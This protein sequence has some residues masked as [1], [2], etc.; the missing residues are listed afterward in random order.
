MMTMRRAVV[1]LFLLFAAV[2][3]SAAPALTED[4]RIAGL[5][6]IWSEAKFGFVYFD[7]VPELDWD[8][9]YLDYLPRVRAAASTLDYYKL[10]SRFV[11]Q[12]KDGHTDVTPPLQ[13][14]QQL[15][16]EPALR[17]GE[18]EERVVVT[19]IFD[20]AL[21]IARGTELIAVDGVPVRQYAAERVTPYVSASTPQDLAQ[22][23]WRR[24][25]WGAEGSDVELTL[26]DA[27]GATV[28][29][30]V[31]RLTSEEEARILPARVPFELRMLPGRIAY[32]ALNEFDDAKAAD[33]F[34]AKFDEIAKAGALILDIRRNG[35][36]SS[37]VG[38]R[39]LA[40]LTA[41]PFRTSMWK[42]R[43]YSATARAW[44]E[45]ERIAVHEAEE[46]RPNGTRLFTNPVVV[47]TSARTFSAA[48]DFAVAFDAMKRGAIIGEPTGGST[49][50]PLS[51]PLPGGG[52]ARICTKHDVYPD[53]REFVGVGVQ[54]QLV[55][56]PTL[57]DVRAGRDTVL[58]AAIAFLTKR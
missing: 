1:V 12:L 2:A 54:P 3:A 41:K 15:N 44:G 25:L 22:R 32:I 11:A 53:G 43:I 27:G 5:S 34:D 7:R 47:L 14:Q 13:V 39:V 49:G 31:R 8:A 24:L 40:S 48:E 56:H 50:Q 21:A 4:Q 38:Y 6:R 18:I 17:L 45:P 16:G 19:D 51:F 30:S 42:T 36:G 37:S 46:V 33:A 23:T 35:G 9:S 55:V 57:A 58:D 28:R 26:R 20:P 29:R 10:L 52:S